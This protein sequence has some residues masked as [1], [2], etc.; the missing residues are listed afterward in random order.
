MRSLPRLEAVSRTDVWI[1]KPGNQNLKAWA[2]RFNSQTLI[3]DGQGSHAA[4][5]IMF[6]VGLHKREHIISGLSQDVISVK[7]SLRQILKCHG[8]F[9]EMAPLFFFFFLVGVSRVCK[10]MPQAYCHVALNSKPFP[11]VYW[12]S[13]HKLCPC[14]SPSSSKI[15]VECIS[16]NS[17]DSGKSPGIQNC[18]IKYRK[19]L[20]HPQICKSESLAL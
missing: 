4:R 14:H 1:N 12:P 7:M 20:S 13:C 15:T 5:S 6:S 11:S 17:S 18:K 19:L 16:W 9:A 3:L 10:V 8:K 2:G